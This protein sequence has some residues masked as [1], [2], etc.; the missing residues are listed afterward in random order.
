MLRDRGLPG[1]GMTPVE[2][3]L[4]RGLS[5]VL[6]VLAALRLLVNKLP[7]ADFSLGEAPSP[8]RLAPKP[9]QVYAR[10]LGR[11][12]ITEP[13]RAKPHRAHESS[14]GRSPSNFRATK[15]IGGE[16]PS[17]TK[18][19]ATSH[20][21]HE[22]SR[23]RSHIKLPRGSNP[24]AQR[25]RGEAFLRLQHGSRRSPRPPSS[26]QKFLGGEALL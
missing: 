21:G 13:S 15:A 12:P 11:R 4:R 14:R 8:K 16:A 22:S 3:P 6:P 19:G 1:W 5:Q 25:D 10:N 20:Q 17:Q 18:A 2:D 7:R 9:H 24:Q 26:E 23:G